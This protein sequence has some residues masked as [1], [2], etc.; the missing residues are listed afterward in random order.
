M[1]EKKYMDYRPFFASLLAL[2]LLSSTCKNCT[3]LCKEI[4]IIF[5]PDSYMIY[6]DKHHTYFIKIRFAL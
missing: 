2:G 1:K 4:F 3:H 5:I 6:T